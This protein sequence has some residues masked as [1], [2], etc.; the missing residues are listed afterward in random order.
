MIL[1]NPAPRSA[2][3]DDDI[4]QLI[5]RYG[6]RRVAMRVAR[7][8]LSPRRQSDAETLPSHLRRDIGL[9]PQPPVVRYWELR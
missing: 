5:H 1:T 3:I 4:A 9:P 6:L 8:L 2:E 7:L